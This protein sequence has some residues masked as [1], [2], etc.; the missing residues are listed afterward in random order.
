MSGPRA[1]VVGFGS[2]GR[3]HARLLAEAGCEVA[4][5]SRHGGG[6]FSTVAA[7][8]QG[9][10]PDYVV[11][12][13]ETLDHARV[14]AELAECGYGGRLA[15]EK[16]LFDLRREF[17]WCG[18]GPTVVAYPLRCHPAMLALKRELGDQPVL[19]AQFYVGQ[20]LPDWRPG[21][22][23]RDSYSAHAVQGGGALRDLS[24]ELDLANWLLGPW[25][26]V[27]ARGGHWSSLQIDSDDVFVLLSE[28]ERCPAAT[29]QVNYLDRRLRRTVLLHTDRHSYEVDL[30]G[31][32]LQRDAEPPQVFAIE[33]DVM[34]RVM[35]ASMLDGDADHLC[36]V[37]EGLRVL[38]MV[39]AAERSART[40]TW[41]NSQG[42]S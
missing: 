34:F 41:E 37:A 14:L 6:A 42:V 3:R 11:V 38:E 30:I 5:V 25:C 29:I 27:A 28:H 7:G 31:H 4:V 23:Y 21:T 2:I 19:A 20:Y 16:P 9:H 33:R 18:F 32:S 1:L 36:R 40:A 15:I 22:D 26:R 24:H 17:P 12:A 10:D 39:A 8:V 13:T 35:H